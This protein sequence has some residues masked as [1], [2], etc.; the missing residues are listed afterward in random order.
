MSEPTRMVCGVCGRTLD[1]ITY[2]RDDEA[3]YR[4]TMQDMQGGEDHPAVPVEAGT[5]AERGRCDFCNVDEPTMVVPVESFEYRHLPGHNSLGDWA[6]CDECARLI[7]MGYWN[8][9]IKRVL[10]IDP[11]PTRMPP[12][13]HRA[14][15]VELYN[16]LGPHITGKPRPI[17]A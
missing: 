3:R 17:N 7:G 2:D 13:V 14:V 4:H 5:I 8:L 10:A 9:L 15:L 6:A 11:M 12:G 1:V 16:E